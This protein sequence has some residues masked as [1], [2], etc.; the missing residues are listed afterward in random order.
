MYGFWARRRK[1]SEEESPLK[2]LDHWIWVNSSHILI[3][4]PIIFLPPPLRQ[5]QLPHTF[6]NF[7]WQAW[8]RWSQ[9]LLTSQLGCVDFKGLLTQL[10]APGPGARGAGLSEMLEP[11]LKSSKMAKG[12]ISHPSSWR[13]RCYLGNKNSTCQSKPVLSNGPLE[14]GNYR[15][16]S[17]SNPF[18]VTAEVCSQL[19][20]DCRQNC[21][22]AKLL[23][24]FQKYLGP[25]ETIL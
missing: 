7:L 2:E 4:D 24:S 10:Q 14:F 17:W 20:S 12:P 13:E 19:M 25:S 15:P 8:W 22:S 23:W 3:K 11:Y 21:P 6:P 5:H 18:S 1:S 16:K 9:G